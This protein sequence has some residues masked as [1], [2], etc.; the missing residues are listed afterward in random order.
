MKLLY[1]FLLFKV[2]HISV[3]STLVIRLEGICLFR[4]IKFNESDD[5]SDIQRH[6]TKVGQA[7]INSY[8]YL[9]KQ[10]LVKLQNSSIL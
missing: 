9:I 3:I 4:R 1:E 2:Q 6:I 5:S 8:L 10:T 7:Y